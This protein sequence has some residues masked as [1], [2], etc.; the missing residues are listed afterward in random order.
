MYCK[1]CGAEINEEWSLCPYC[2]MEQNN[3]SGKEVHNSGHEA[4][5]KIL[6]I[7]SFGDDF[8]FGNSK[9][10]G[11]MLMKIC[12]LI[13]IICFFCPMY[14]VS[15]AG[16]EVGRLSGLD[17]TF[18][19]SYMDEEISG[20]LIFGLL[21]LLPLISLSVCCSKLKEYEL[22]KRVEELRVATYASAVCMTMTIWF[23]LYFEGKM[24]G[25]LAE[26]M[27]KLH[28]LF[29]RNLS[30]LAESIFVMIGTFLAFLLEPE[31]KDGKKRNRVWIA[32]CCVG[33]VLGSSLI[34]L[35]ILFAIVNHFFPVEIM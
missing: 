34:L 7:H 21:F 16:T 22:I 9:L 12:A 25:D 14:M 11:R 1:H 23:V 24:A 6:K 29:A 32:V 3:R 18:G 10:T 2:G 30:L 35:S 20:N 26:N 31:E 28:P 15:C 19:F 8:S 5:R 4:L 33:K 17:F 27:I 13:A